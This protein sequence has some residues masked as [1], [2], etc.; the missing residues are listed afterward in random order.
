M[1]L[2]GTCPSSTETTSCQ[3]KHRFSENEKPTLKFSLGFLTKGYH[4]LKVFNE[5]ILRRCA[6][7]VITTAHWNVFPNLFAMICSAIAVSAW[8]HSNWQ[9]EPQKNGKYGK[10]DLLAQFVFLFINETVPVHG[11]QPSQNRFTESHWILA[12]IALYCMETSTVDVPLPFCRT[13]PR[14]PRPQSLILDLWTN[15]SANAPL[16]KVTVTKIPKGTMR[17]TTPAR[18]SPSRSAKGLK[19]LARPWRKTTP[20]WRCF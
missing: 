6:M 19:S 11:H 2:A 4:I 15:P 20:R 17:D 16:S 9:Q 12:Q 3:K 8:N 7:E 1:P 18:I 10:S 13:G 5:A 14:I